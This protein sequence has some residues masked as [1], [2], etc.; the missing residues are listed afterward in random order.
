MVNWCAAF[1]GTIALQIYNEKIRKNKNE[2][3]WQQLSD[4]WWTKTGIRSPI[5]S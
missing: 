3:R 2:D 4:N 1:A 5:F